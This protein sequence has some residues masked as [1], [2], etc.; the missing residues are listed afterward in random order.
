MEHPDPL[1]AGLFLDF[2]PI[3]GPAII[4]AGLAIL[5]YWY[6]DT[7]FL[8]DVTGLP[9]SGFQRALIT[10]PLVSGF[11]LGLGVFVQSDHAFWMYTA[12]LFLSGNA[13]KGAALVRTIKKFASRI[14]DVSGSN[15]SLLSK[16][17]RLV[18]RLVARFKY[19]VISLLFLFPTT[20]AVF[21][22]VVA[23]GGSVLKASVV[24]WSLFVA[25]TILWTLS[26]DLRSISP[27]GT[28]VGAA[29]APV[30]ATIIWVA[31]AEVVNFPAES[32]PYLNRLSRAVS[33]IPLLEFA[34]ALRV[35]VPNVVVL[36]AAQVALMVGVFLALVFWW[37][38]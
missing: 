28:S 5:L 38:S 6:A 22:L 33:P 26:W 20:I 29:R 10:V 16:A 8:Q 12:T 31:G 1:Q 11:L 35:S 17:G 32:P 37:S 25:G 27:A 30:F 7:W 36:V 4:S 3:V 15:G 9:L 21:I 19:R 14:T 18:S 34:T 23:N 13:I 24:A 2:H